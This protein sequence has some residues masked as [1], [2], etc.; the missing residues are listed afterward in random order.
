MKL[1]FFLTRS[2]RFTIYF[3]LFSSAAALIV[4]AVVSL[5]WRYFHDVPIMIY[6]ARLIDS[7]FVPYKDFFD[8][9]TPGIYFISFFAAKIF[10]WS[11]LSFRIFDLL[12]LSA[13][14]FFTALWLK[15]FGKL[16][17]VSSALLFGLYYLNDT[18]YLILQRE[19]IALLPLSAML[20]LT[21]SVIKLSKS[22]ILFLS[23]ILTGICV[24]IKPQFI[25][26]SLPAVL[27]FIFR[28]KF[29]NPSY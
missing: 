1:N 13:L 25:L 19:Y 7:G 11:D 15:P 20:W 21:S 10:G 27:F 14:L 17:S 8:M 26:L 23:G 6:C 5:D 4:S 18:P 12:C 2:I 16:A 28:F 29:Q 22:K 24:S 3:L 9:N